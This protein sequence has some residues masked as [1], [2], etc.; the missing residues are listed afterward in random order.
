MPKLSEAELLERDAMRDLDAE[1]QQAIADSKAGIYARKTEFIPQPDGGIRRLV[2]LAD[3]SIERDE[4]LNATASVRMRSGLSQS[5]FAE[6]L[7][8]SIR[9]LQDWEQGRR[10]PS[11]AA[12]TLLKVAAKHPDIFLEL[13]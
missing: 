3:G 4:I 6:L 11:G 1:L 8:V 7:G 13:S 12:S 5:R 10:T 9:T 2:T